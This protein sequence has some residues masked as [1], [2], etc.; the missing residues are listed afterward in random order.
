MSVMG[1]TPPFRQVAALDFIRAI[2][3][4]SL[5]R[6]CSK[7]SVRLIAVELVGCF[8]GEPSWILV[9]HRLGH[10]VC[11]IFGEM[12]EDLSQWSEHLDVPS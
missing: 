1:S 6:I 10:V 7:E 3:P 12:T 11:I 8:V 9:L 4:T 2:S 5:I